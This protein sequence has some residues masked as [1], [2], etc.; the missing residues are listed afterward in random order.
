VTSQLP[1]KTW[2]DAMQDKPVADAI[3]DRLVHNGYKLELKGESM[4]P[5]P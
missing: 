3:L 2:H 1:V 5:V 4:L